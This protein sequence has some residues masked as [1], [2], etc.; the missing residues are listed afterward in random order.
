M[1]NRERMNELDDKKLATLIVEYL[2]K[3]GRSWT[4]AIYG[5]KEWLGDTAYEEEWA[6][7]KFYIF[8]EQ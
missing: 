5:V 4:S 1:T 7:I 3:V 8:G 2:P 6:D